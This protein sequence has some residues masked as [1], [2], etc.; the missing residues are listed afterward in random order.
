MKVL[1]L[2][3]EM[4]IS[5]VVEIDKVRVRD[6]DKDKQEDKEIVEEEQGLL[7]TAVV[8]EGVDGV[9]L[10]DRITS[11]RWWSTHGPQSLII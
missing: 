10:D 11:P 6:K 9:E 5:Q 2:I 1:N 7:I 4:S 8:V 3:V